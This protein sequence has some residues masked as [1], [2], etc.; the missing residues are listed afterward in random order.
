MKTKRQSIIDIRRR[1]FLKTVNNAGISSGL[2][3]AS[4][5]ATGMMLSRAAESQEASGIEQVIFVFVPG[6]APNVNG[7]SSFIPTDINDLPVTSAPLASVSD[8]IVFLSDAEVSGGG[9]HGNTPKVF[10]SS[11]QRESYDVQLANYYGDLY[12][13]SQLLLGVQSGFGNHGYATL[14]AINEHTS[15]EQ[16]YQDSPNVAFN[17]IFNNVDTS[18]NTDVDATSDS[19]R[20]LSILD[21]QREEILAL[22]GVLGSFENQRLEEHLSSIESIR[23]RLLSTSGS[24]T[25]CPIAAD[26]NP[27]GF[28]YDSAIRDNF[29]REAELQ[30]DIA[31]ASLNCKLTNNVSIMLGN[32]QCENF[33]NSWNWTDVY[34]QSIHSGNTDAYIETRSYF[35]EITAYLIE[36][37]QANN[38][39]ENTLVVQT[40]DM[41]EGNGHTSDRAPMFFAGGGS[42]VN[43]GMVTSMGSNLGH[44]AMFDT[45]T[46]LLGVNL[47]YIGG[48]PI[49]GVIA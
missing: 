10:G 34:H 45:V 35:T 14:R 24:V 48:G 19:T 11:G 26:F 3:K 28:V 32:H 36:R 8:E 7:A 12:P 38:M 6:G 44:N 46:D 23:N 31:V 20:A 33:D 2:L 47:P 30:I 25:S 16:A 5:L 17:T 27:D 9:G 29:R 21:V 13:Y 22:Q 15:A 40:T 42:S 4:G 39:L 41:G 49:P 37:L 43:T 1:E 18:G